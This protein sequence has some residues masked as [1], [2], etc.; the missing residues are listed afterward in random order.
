[1]GVG[2][3][4]LGYI[5]HRVWEAVVIDGLREVRFH[6]PLCGQ[7]HRTPVCT[8]HVMS[9]CS[10]PMCARACGHVQAR[11]RVPVVNKGG[12]VVAVADG[13]GRCVDQVTRK[14]LVI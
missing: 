6:D 8:V 5:V 13:S 14:G 10:T 3:V 4:W 9:A 2:V 7:V 1:M 12:H 11:V